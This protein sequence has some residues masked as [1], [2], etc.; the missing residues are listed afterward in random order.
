M[1]TSKQKK[2]KLKTQDTEKK[3]RKSKEQKSAWI[4]HYFF[5]LHSCLYIHSFNIHLFAYVLRFLHN[6]VV[7]VANWHVSFLFVSIVVKICHNFVVL[8]LNHLERKLYKA[9]QNKFSC[10]KPLQPDE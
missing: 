1:K 5:V 3:I 4:D 2:R 6:T 9:H 7:I 10:L 8:Q